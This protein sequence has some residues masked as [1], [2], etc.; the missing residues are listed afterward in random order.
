MIP[1]NHNIDDPDR[2]IRTQG[3]SCRGI[4]I[5][6]DVWIGARVVVLDGVTI[7]RGAVIGAG[8]VVT[9]DVPAGAIS[10]GVPA[11]VKRYRDVDRFPREDRRHTPVSNGVTF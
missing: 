2:P 1:A 3:L 4:V 10:M 9:Q 8:A 5:E 6:D 7:R 11:K